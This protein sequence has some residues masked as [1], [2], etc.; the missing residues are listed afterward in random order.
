M[1]IMELYIIRVL[2][3]TNTLI[4]VCSDLITKPIAPYF[5]TKVLETNPRQ[6]NFTLLV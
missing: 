1:N 5:T 4:V 2:N 6:I 3:G